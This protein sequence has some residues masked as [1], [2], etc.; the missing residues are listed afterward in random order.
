MGFNFWLFRFSQISAAMGFSASSIAIVWWVLNE[1]HKLIY[2]SYVI[3]P[4]LIIT[5]LSQ[6][7]VAPAGDRLSKKNLLVIGCLIQSLSYLV[8]AFILKNNSMNLIL[9][10]SVEVVAAIG[11]VVFNAGSI[12]ILPHLVEQNKISDGI[13]IID[14]INSVVSILGGIF[15]GFFVSMLGVVNSFFLYTF[16]L[17]ASCILCAFIHY[18][19]EEEGIHSINWFE[20]VKTGFLYTIKNPVISGFFFFS[21]FLGLA[22]SP[23]LIAFPY[24]I[25]Q[26]NELPAFFIG[27]LSASLGLGTIAGSLVYN[28]VSKVTSKSLIIYMSSFFFFCSIVFVCIMKDV[29]SLFICEFLIGVSRCWI[30]VTVDTM[31]LLHLP[32]NMRTKVLSNM[33]FFSMINMPVAMFFS[34]Y[35][36][37]YFG[38]YNFLWI[39]SAIYLIASAILIF[40]P[41]VRLFLMATPEKATLMLKN[42]IYSKNNE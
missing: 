5:A 1:Y 19:N 33:M 34:G 12:G 4:A 38:I 14:R 30:N 2:V 20:D 41:K 22:F 39:L 10:M 9:L 11:K 26:M 42:H 16:C 28:K 13:N 25:K 32:E 27:I 18:K 21:L 7:L 15:G 17:L 6:P 3:I 24:I 40:N 36:M 37:D 29:T 8:A 23:M 31:L 35:L